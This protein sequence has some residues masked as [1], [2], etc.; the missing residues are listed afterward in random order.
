MVRLS[1]LFLLSAVSSNAASL[2][3][4]MLGRWDADGM[5]L[6]ADY[7]DFSQDLHQAVLKQTKT[8]AIN[9]SPQA[10]TA[11]PTWDS[12]FIEG[13]GLDATVKNGLF[14]SLYMPDGRY[15]AL[16]IP[17]SLERDTRLTYATVH[18]RRCVFNRESGNVQTRDGHSVPPVFSESCK[19]V[20]IYSLPDGRIGWETGFGWLMLS[21][22][23]ASVPPPLGH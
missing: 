3:S 9:V 19:P 16:G 8:L 12:D 5:L 14:G 13:D 21:R 6:Q 1:L 2:P 4:W 17:I 10:I 18:M 20:R 15:V 7:S 23:V 22:H 11:V